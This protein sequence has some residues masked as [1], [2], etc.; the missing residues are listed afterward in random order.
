MFGPL[1]DLKLKWQLMILFLAVGLT[2]LLISIFTASQSATSALM[3]TAYNQLQSVRE[4]KKVQIEKYFNER[5]GDMGVLVETVETLSEEAFAKLTAVRE[6]KRSAVTRYL[7]TVSNQASLFAR[8]PSTVVNMRRFRTEIAD[9]EDLE[10]TTGLDTQGVKKSLADY[11]T[12]HFGKTYQAKRGTA[13]TSDLLEQLDTT[14]LAMQYHY[15]A[16][17][18]HPLGNKHQLDAASDGSTYSEHH[19]QAHPYMRDFLERFGYYDIF[20]ADIETGR[21][22]YSVFKELDYGL[23]LK[24]GSLAKTNFAQAFKAAAASNTPGSVHVV[25]FAPYWPSYEAP[26]GFIASPIFDGGKKIGVALFQFPIDRLNSI[27]S[28]RAGMGKSGE[29]YLVGP[30]QLMRSDSFLDPKHHTVEASFRDPV[31]GKVDTLASRHAI[32]GKAETRVVQDYN[33]NPV[34]SSY[35]PI[36]VGDITW[37]LLAEID[38]AE[39]FSPVDKKGEEFFKRYIDMYGYY[40]LFL[41]NPDGFVYYT[42]TREADYQTNMV[43]GQYKDSN[44]GKLV[45]QVIETKKIGFADFAPY[46]PS[47]GAPAAFLAQPLVVDGQ[48]LTI[49]AVQLPLEG[50]NGIMQERTGMGE[51]GET[52]LVGPDKRMRSDSF[53]DKQGHSVKASFAGTIAKNGVDTEAVRE[54]QANKVDARVIVDYNG[55]PV[56]SAFTPVQVFDQKWS[57]LA[58]KDEAE[59]LIPVHALQQFMY[60]VALVAAIL[61]TLVAIMVARALAN[62]LGIELNDLIEIFRR[63]SMGDLTVEL[64]DVPKDSVASHLKKMRQCLIGSVRTLALQSHSLSAVVSEQDLTNT[65]LRQASQE[66]HT[67]ARSVVAEN[68]K[69]D[70]EISDLGDILNTSDVSLVAL[71]ETAQTLSENVNTIAAASEEASQNV[72][73][74]ASAAEEMTSNIDQ[75]NTSLNS[76]GSA[77]QSVVEAVEEMSSLT[78]IV[79]EGVERAEST[80][81]EA[82]SNTQSTQEIMNALSQST[83]E[84]VKVVGMIK[85]IADQTNML[86][87]NASIEAAGAGEAGKGFAVVANEVKE[88]AQQTAD[89]TKQIDDKTSEIREKSRSARDATQYIGDLI[90]QLNTINDDISNAMSSQGEAVDRIVQSI[91]QVDQDNKEVIRNAAELSE[92]SSEVARAALEAATGTQE[93]AQSTTNIAS[94]AEEVAEN[95]AK[96]RSNQEQTKEFT[97]QVFHSSALVQKVMLQSMDMSDRLDGYVAG[98]VSLL[99]VALDSSK[100]LDEAQKR[101]NAGKALFDVEAIKRDQLAWIEQ[102][103]Q[104][105]RGHHRIQVE[106]IPE[107]NQTPFGQWY[108]NP[109]TQQFHSSDETFQSM[110]PLHNKLYATLTE[111]VELAHEH[112]MD[113]ANARLED[114]HAMR[115][116]LFES[117]DIVYIGIDAC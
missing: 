74:M 12:N 8:N 18:S 114:L 108:H 37:G 110:G 99:D 106:K 54:A 16:N 62:K 35:A 88:L 85:N 22:V 24:Q 21:I 41:I 104:Q 50:I 69:I 14:A 80:S 7:E 20:L 70:S 68:D 47:N 100:S 52:Y 31:K 71:G 60:A 67:M 84:I 112:K 29:T 27:M 64:G 61:V 26:A 23:S 101:F 87:L 45:R 53:L 44:L 56:L 103:I 91:D 36:K 116:D 17:N 78:E 66:N 89:A 6:T 107:E 51:T 95:T 57:L 10:A 93:I 92:A 13:P 28:E 15:I 38:V 115:K 96:V 63:I 32:A 49:I 39:A 75:V 77:I 33:N 19:R 3:D 98:A 11:Y 94:G 1:K 48:I 46:A 83:D 86:A 72:S 76:V 97:K 58:E 82:T 65:K 43:S 9:Y 5:Q 81:K 109:V 102:L 73:T 59:V 55:N 113:Q 90:N 42:A 79:Y 105:L 40:D 30:D 4:I 2:P 25:D 34:L 117:L 111:I